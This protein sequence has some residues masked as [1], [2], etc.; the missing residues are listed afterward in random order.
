[1]PPRIPIPSLPHRLPNSLSLH[2]TRTRTLSTPSAPSYDIHNA[3]SPT[4]PQLPPRRRPIFQS[5]G[6]GIAGG[7]GGGGVGRVVRNGNT[8]T[9]TNTNARREEE[10]GPDGLDM[11]EKR[12]IGVQTENEDIKERVDGEDSEANYTVRTSTLSLFFFF[13]SLSFIT[14]L[15]ITTP[16]GEYILT[17]SNPFFLLPT[18]Q[19]AP[20][21]HPSPLSHIPTPSPLLPPST[22]IL[23]PILLLPLLSTSTSNRIRDIR[24]SLS[25]TR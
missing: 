15:P 1:M 20:F 4:P 6:F 25:Q 9:N 3:Q 7:G 10:V 5:V 22:P 2:Y 21:I 16:Q 11:G 24:Y 17:Y 13:L 23:I 12:Q 19:P 18:N 14:R 8:N